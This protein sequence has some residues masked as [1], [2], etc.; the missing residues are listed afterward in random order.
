MFKI[1]GKFYERFFV[2]KAVM[3]M[4]QAYREGKLVP[5][6]Y[7]IQTRNCSPDRYS[8][9]TLKGGKS[10]EVEVFINAEGKVIITPAKPKQPN[11]CLDGYRYLFDVLYA[12]YKKTVDEKNAKEAEEKSK[13]AQSVISEM[14][15]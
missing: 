6:E 12:D 11:V 2:K 13:Y 9:I 7:E 3:D 8:Y 14:L 15:Q 10:G 1:L 5:Y 4:V